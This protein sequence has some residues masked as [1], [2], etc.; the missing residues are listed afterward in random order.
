LAGNT[1]NVEGAAPKVQ[2]ITAPAVT[3]FPITSPVNNCIEPPSVS[4]A[5]GLTLP[6]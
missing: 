6:R 2:L 5:S 1:I 4:T 3:K